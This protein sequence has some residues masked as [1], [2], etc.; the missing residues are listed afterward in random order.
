MSYMYKYLGRDHNFLTPADLC[1]AVESYEWAVKMQRDS[2]ELA[3]D[4]RRWQKSAIGITQTA[5]L[6]KHGRK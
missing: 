4:L 5:L 2:A 1:S 6:L 3:Q